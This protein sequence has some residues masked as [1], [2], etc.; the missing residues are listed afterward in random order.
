MRPAP[1]GP[2]RR[3]AGKIT[4]RSRNSPGLYDVVDS[5][6][7]GTTF[8]LVHDYNGIAEW[9]QGR[10]RMKDAVI[11]G[12]IAA[13]RLRAMERGLSIAFYHQRGHRAVSYNEYARY[14]ARA[15]AL[16]TRGATA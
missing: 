16:A 12:I 9:M 13:C 15:D 3:G 6:A 14:N 10:W 8:I 4:Q 5:I 11:R 2:I 7:A 1:R